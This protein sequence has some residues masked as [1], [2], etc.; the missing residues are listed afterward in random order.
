MSTSENVFVK[1]HIN[2]DERIPSFIFKYIWLI[3]G[4]Q[5]EFRKHPKIKLNISFNKPDVRKTLN[6]NISG[7]VNTIMIRL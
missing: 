5:Y 4:N 3:K 2:S 7:N 6:I 1:M